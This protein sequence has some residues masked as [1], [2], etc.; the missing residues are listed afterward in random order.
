M[1]RLGYCAVLLLGFC[2]SSFASV[3]Y[4]SQTLK[5]T[6]KLAYRGAK[7]SAK[8]ASYPVRHP[9][10]TSKGLAKGTA[11]TVTAVF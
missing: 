1:Q 4:V 6:A 5:P 8:V 9:V 3:H 10:K 2:A 7:A 11:K